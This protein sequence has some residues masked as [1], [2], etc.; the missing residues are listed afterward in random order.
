[1]H[2]PTQH[3]QHLSHKQII[4][5]F[6]VKVINST[7]SLPFLHMHYLQYKLIQCLSSVHL[8]GVISVVVLLILQEFDERKRLE[9]CA[10]N[11]HSSVHVFK[12]DLDTF[13][14][15]TYVGVPVSMTSMVAIQS[16]QL[17]WLL[18]SLND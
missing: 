15:I 7:L 1:M 4:F 14:C 13:E 8:K 2:T 3:S 11:Y 12:L 6:D 5:Q 17:V 9:T 18:S 16:Q 10:I